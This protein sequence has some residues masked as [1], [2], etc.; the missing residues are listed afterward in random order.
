MPADACLKKQI[1]D[2]EK[3]THALPVSDSREGD[4]MPGRT[5]VTA[6]T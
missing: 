1:S 4:F 5:V 3:T 6:F 2:C